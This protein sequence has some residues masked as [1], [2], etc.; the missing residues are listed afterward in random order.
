MGKFIVTTDINTAEKLFSL[1]CNCIYQDGKQWRFLNAF[2]DSYEL[3]E[4]IDL[5]NITF[6]NVMMF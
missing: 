2:E 5:K 4:K 3:K 1:G 6:S